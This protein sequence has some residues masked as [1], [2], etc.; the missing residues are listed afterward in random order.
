MS[1]NIKQRNDSNRPE[2]IRL[3]KGG[4]QCPYTGLTR[5]KLNQLILPAYWD[6]GMP[7]VKSILLRPDGCQRG[8]R[9]INYQ[10]LIDYLYSKM[11][12]GE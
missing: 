7:P 10:S 2:F 1:D 9:L 6:D 4:G 3:P 8:A 5:S 12:G 11:E